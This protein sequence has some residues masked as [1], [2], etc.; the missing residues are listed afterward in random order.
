[1]REIVVVIF[2]FLLGAVAAAPEKEIVKVNV[3]DTQGNP[4]ENAFVFIDV[5]EGHDFGS[6]EMN[7]EGYYE[8]H[9]PTII[10]GGFTL[11]VCA[12]GYSS[13]EEAY[14]SLPTSSIEVTLEPVTYS[15]YIIKG[16]VYETPYESSAGGPATVG[17]T[18]P[19]AGVPLIVRGSTECGPGVEL[20][21]LVTNEYGH[22]SAKVRGDV[23]VCIDYEEERYHGG[24]AHFSLEDRKKE[25]N[26]YTSKRYTLEIETKDKSGRQVH[27]NI[28]RVLTCTSGYV[29]ANAGSRLDL[30]IK[31]PKSLGSCDLLAYTMFAGGRT[32]VPEIGWGIT[33]VSVTMDREIE[34][35]SEFIPE[36]SED[37]IRL[38][39]GWNLVPIADFEQGTCP[40]D[41]S[42]VFI[43]D[44]EAQ[45][46]LRG[47][48]ME[49]GP[50]E[51]MKRASLWYYSTIP[52][53]TPVGSGD[54]RGVAANDIRLSAGWNLLFVTRDM[55]GH[56]LGQMKGNC[57]IL[58]SA[59]WDPSIQ[60][61][62][63]VGE[64][65]AFPEVYSG[66]VTRA[67]SGCKFE[68]GPKPIDDIPGFEFLESG[69][70]SIGDEGGTE[71][72]YSRG[73]GEFKVVFFTVTKDELEKLFAQE[74]APKSISIESVVVDGTAY[75]VYY[76]SEGRKTYIWYHDSWFF[77]GGADF[78]PALK[79]EVIDV[80]E[81]YIAKYPPT[82]T[83]DFLQVLPSA[84]S[85]GEVP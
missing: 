36:L 49:N 16:Y 62:Q 65:F 13:K 40:G 74:G 37:S 82:D 19:L 39:R 61:W 70:S 48:E 30:R 72:S 60:S 28:K 35:M 7:E 63:K 57:D 46:Y 31:D 1:M 18:T 15:E 54:I 25:N 9:V 10:G 43:W 11:R 26:I 73:G 33:K 50:S 41:P 47:S 29:R 14:S 83:L 32:T 69:R 84:P 56:S 27:S 21:R 51:E 78:S 20:A 67:D 81:P 23:D 44:P 75:D 52:C 22:F 6:N 68:L 85:F 64:D 24:C 79:S 2:I 76:V 66:F 77:L 38:Y 80:V 5:S 58:K 12:Y 8:L 4:I 3:L 55:A 59:V 42:Y 34:D 17:E 71:V 45:Q 53:Q